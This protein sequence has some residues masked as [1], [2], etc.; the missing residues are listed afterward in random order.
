MRSQSQI[1][2]LRI[3]WFALLL[4]AFLY[5]GIGYGVLAKN[6]HPPQVPIMPMALGG[7]SVIV[8]IMSLVMPIFIYRQTVKRMDVKTTQEVA[9]NVFPDRYREA[10]PK[11]T[12]FADPEAAMKQAYASFMTP[13]I[14]SLALSEAIATFGLV[15]VQLGFETVQSAPFFVTGILLIVLRFPRH[16]QVQGVFERAC[17]AVF[18]A[19]QS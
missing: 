12:V 11:Q 8:A 1:L 18:P 4:A 19:Q 9:P 6:P 16:A 5:V 10:M 17:G 3:L 13:F 15:L 2:V 7:L 14:L